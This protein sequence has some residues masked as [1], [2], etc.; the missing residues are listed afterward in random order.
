MRY[1]YRTHDRPTSAK[2]LDNTGSATSLPKK[3][4]LIAV[5]VLQSPLHI[6]WI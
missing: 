2:A 4:Q 6:Y 3:A 5:E 1:I